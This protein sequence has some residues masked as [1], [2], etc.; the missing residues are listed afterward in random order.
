ML[1]DAEFAR[2]WPLY[3][4]GI[5]SLKADPLPEDESR[6]PGF[7]EAHLGKASAEYE[8]LTGVPELRPSMV[9][10]HQLSRF[11]PPCTRCGKPL[12]GPQAN[13]CAACGTPR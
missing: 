5:L 6:P 12:R 10:H 9:H 13:Y 3:E 2:V 11:G 7:L 4:A 1:D 8:R